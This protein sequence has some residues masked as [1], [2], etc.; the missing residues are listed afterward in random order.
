MPVPAG[1]L[2]RVLGEQ[3]RV[4][5]RGVGR[6]TRTT[7]PVP[8]CR[9]RLAGGGTDRGLAGGAAGGGS[10]F[11]MVAAAVA[12]VGRFLVYPLHIPVEDEGTAVGA[13]RGMQGDS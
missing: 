13:V 2:D 9:R 5:S 12:R 4:P 7:V 1:W 3:Q 10:V 6:W 11:S 8:R